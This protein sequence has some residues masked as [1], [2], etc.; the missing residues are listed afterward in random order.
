MACI[1]A[2]FIAPSRQDLS[3]RYRPACLQPVSWLIRFIARGSMA[4]LPEVQHSLLYLHDWFSRQV[5]VQLL[6]VHICCVNRPI[7]GLSNTYL[8][9]EAAIPATSTH[10]Q[11]MRPLLVSYNPPCQVTRWTSGHESSPSFKHRKLFRQRPQNHKRDNIQ[12]AFDLRLQRTSPAAPANRNRT[13]AGSGTSTSEISG[14]AK[15]P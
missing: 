7:A 2:D 14:D 15:D 8:D 6:Q 11:R 3:R 5:D 1:D 9:T 10:Q 12:T 13:D 4:A